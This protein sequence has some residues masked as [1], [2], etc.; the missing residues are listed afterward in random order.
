LN[1][2]LQKEKKEKREREKQEKQEMKEKKRLAKLKLDGK[3]DVGEKE[4]KIHTDSMAH[5]HLPY[6][7]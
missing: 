5:S 6:D 4:V 7:F 2:T 1:K 3:E